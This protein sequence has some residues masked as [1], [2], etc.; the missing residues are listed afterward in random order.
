MQNTR[1]R[2]KGTSRRAFLKKVTAAASAAA[3]N[4][5]SSAVLRE[6]QEPPVPARR[7]PAKAK[8]I[9]IQVGAV[10]FADEGVDNVLDILQERAGINALMLA[11]F[12][13]ARAIA[14]R[15]IPGQPLT[16]AAAHII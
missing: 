1:S 14:A 5:L 13:Y 6:D 10:S 4:N 7:A 16:D 8:F 11:V 9:A 2:T 12:T 15:Q 3:T